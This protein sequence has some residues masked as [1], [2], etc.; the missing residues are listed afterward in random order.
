MK[1]INTKN[2][3]GAELKDAIASNK[4][5]IAKCAT[6]LELFDLLEIATKRTIMEAL[7]MSEYM[8]GKYKKEDLMSSAV[9]QEFRAREDAAKEAAAKAGREALESGRSFE[10]K[11]NELAEISENSPK[12][13]AKKY[14]RNAFYAR[15]TIEIARLLELDMP[16]GSTEEDI[17]DEIMTICKDGAEVAGKIR[18]IT[19][20][21]RVEALSFEEK[22]AELS[23]K[24]SK[25]TKYTALS[26]VFDNFTLSDVKEIAGL[27]GV[28]IVQC[29]DKG[30]IL[31]V[32]H[33]AFTNEE[34]ITKLNSKPAEKSE[35]E[36]MKAPVPKLISLNDNSCVIATHKDYLK[37]L[38]H[39][40][41]VISQCQTLDEIRDALLMVDKGS[42]VGIAHA[43]GMSEKIL[44]F[45]QV[46]KSELA[47][48]CTQEILN[49]RNTGDTSFDDHI[50][51]LRCINET[52][53]G[54]VK[55]A[56]KTGLTHEELKRIVR[57]MGFDPEDYTFDY[58]TESEN[59]DKLIDFITSRTWREFYEAEKE[60]LYEEKFTELIKASKKSQKAVNCVMDTLTSKELTRLANALALEGVDDYVNDNYD[61]AESKEL[62]IELIW[63]AIAPANFG[64][65]ITEIIESE[66][67]ARP[68]LSG[69]NW[70]A[71]NTAKNNN[72]FAKNHR[73]M[74]ICRVNREKMLALLNRTPYENLRTYFSYEFGSKV[75]DRDT[76]IEAVLNEYCPKYE[77][78]E[79]EDENFDA[80][81]YQVRYILVD[82]QD[83]Q[84]FLRYV[85]GLKEAEA[86]MLA[87]YFGFTIER[88]H[89]ITPTVKE[90][91]KTIDEAMS[92]EELCELA[93]K[94]IP[95]TSE[96]LKHEIQAIHEQISSLLNAMRVC[97][98]NCKEYSGLPAL[99]KTIWR[100]YQDLIRKNARMT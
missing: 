45:A 15:E 44:D 11:L 8:Y 21:A 96:S 46:N 90:L 26:W 37:A 31:D 73:L 36:V 25:H 40:K 100:H 53:D 71:G 16:A 10:E 70:N 88:T 86:F 72:A 54:S 95:V 27:L 7:N 43:C 55:N 84:E 35:P 68:V 47:E 94:I 56:L 42:M 51:E 65:F 97:D 63:S 89:G 6:R 76:L 57:I 93:L 78:P 69:L 77:A 20:K 14:M 22:L 1:L 49:V 82:R 75:N 48:K 28:D 30:P 34:I 17:L 67:D 81:L 74:N 39:D 18:K 24:L 79:S 85:Y 83:K 61:E 23:E 3:S 52:D 2:L 12:L 33:K 64:E 4:A 62:L 29:A 38:E 99:L 5:M 66:T 58:V 41:E 32:I 92:E 59:K 50:E 13:C 87:E 9:S 91:C 98:R 80:I 60:L 19:E